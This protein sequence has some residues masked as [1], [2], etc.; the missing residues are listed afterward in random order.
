MLLD[1]RGNLWV[2]QYGPNDHPFADAV[3]SEDW[4]IFN[5]EGR[6]LGMVHTPTGFQLSSVRDDLAV[7][8]V[9][10]NDGVANVWVLPIR[11]AAN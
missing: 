7:G 5:P 1:G 3:M 10:G 11:Q 2:R 9:H 4:W 8:I 6:W